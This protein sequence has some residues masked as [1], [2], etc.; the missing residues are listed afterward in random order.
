MTNDTLN[1]EVPWQAWWLISS[2]VP[3]HTNPISTSWSES[4]VSSP[5]G[6][7]LNLNF[8]LPS[9]LTPRL[10]I[11]LFFTPLASTV[12]LFCPK[13]PVS[14]WPSVY[15]SGPTLRLLYRVLSEPLTL[16]FYFPLYVP[17]KYFSIDPCHLGSSTEDTSQEGFFVIA[18]LWTEENCVVCSFWF[19]KLYSF[20][21]LF[22]HLNI[23]LII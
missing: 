6:Q 18:C 9:F 14:S 21:S 22:Q 16:C 7:S 5:Q 19:T 23:P 4:S 12:S 11:S 15:T 1:L 10:S 20:S 8:C 17:T 3:Q 13:V 2:L